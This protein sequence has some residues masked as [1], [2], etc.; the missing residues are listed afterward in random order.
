MKSANR[1]QK[2]FVLSRRSLYSLEQISKSFNAPRD[3]LVE[4]SVHRLLP[5]IINER[6][7]HKRRKEMLV[8]IRKHFDQGMRLLRQVEGALGVEDPLY[9]KLEAVLGT[10]ASAYHQMDDFVEKGRLI[11]QFEPEMGI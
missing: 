7:K 10:Y 5:I 6:R 9:D 11:E 2:T 1:V 3:A 4:Y 8:E